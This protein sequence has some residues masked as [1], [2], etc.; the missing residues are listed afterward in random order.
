MDYSLSLCLYYI[1]QGWAA[2]QFQRGKCDLEGRAGL[3]EDLSATP[4]SSCV[5]PKN[6]IAIAGSWKKVRVRV[7]DGFIS[8]HLHALKNILFFKSTVLSSL[9]IKESIH[10]HI[11]L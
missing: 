1:Q 8:F 5:I 7:A 11:F 6:P 10:I 4:G 2:F 9:N 3:L